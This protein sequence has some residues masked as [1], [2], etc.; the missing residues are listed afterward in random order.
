MAI[1]AA[2][3]VHSVDAAEKNRLRSRIEQLQSDLVAERALSK[4]LREAVNEWYV[5][6]GSGTNFMN[7]TSPILMAGP[8]STKKASSSNLRT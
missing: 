6:L 2:Q 7:H 3:T 4:E 8:H 5:D 1:L